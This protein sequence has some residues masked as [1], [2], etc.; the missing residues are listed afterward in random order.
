MLYFFTI[1]GFRLFST[2]EHRLL[3]DSVHRDERVDS[4]NSAERYSACL[5][6]DSVASAIDWVGFR[7]CAL[8]RVVIKMLCL[9]LHFEIDSQAASLGHS[10]LLPGP[11]TV[12]A[13]G[14]RANSCL[15]F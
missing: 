1:V 6:S 2:S 7:Y 11:D 3:H 5:L 4:V 15:H 9:L 12:G 8:R 14:L 10:L 13:A